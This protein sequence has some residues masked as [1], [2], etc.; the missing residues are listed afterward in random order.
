MKTTRLARRLGLDGNPLRRRTD[1]IAACL[2]ALLLAAFLI[3]APVLSVA[4]VGWAG[5]PGPPS[6]RPRARGIRFPPWCCR[7]RRRPLPPTG[8]SAIPW[9][10]P[11]GPHRTAGRGPAGS[12]SAPAWP[13]AARCGC[14]WTRPARRPAPR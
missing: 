12:R 5:R 4:A 6:C 9:S 3:G 10:W 1:K 13:L 8:S 2:A 11:G 7:R 14:G